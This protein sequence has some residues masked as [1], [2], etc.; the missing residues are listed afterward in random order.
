MVVGIASN[1]GAV[2]AGLLGRHRLGRD[3][4]R[5]LARRASLGEA[6]AALRD[7]PYG[8]D[9][10][11]APTL[12]A[13]Q[14]A[15]AGTPLWHMRVLAGWLPPRGGELVRTLAGWW[16]VLNVEN[17]LA[18]LG[19]AASLPPYD[20][21]RLDTAWR[22]L[23]GAGSAA[24]VRAR[25][26]DSA[27]L[28]P[29]ADDVPTIVTALRLSWSRRVAAE[30]DDAARLAR[31]WAAL[32]IA[33]DLL[34][35]SRT[36]AAAGVRPIRGLGLEHV[37]VG[38]LGH[39]RTTLPRDAAWVLDDV[40]VPADLW[41]AEVRWWRELDVAGGRMLG[42][43]VSGAQAVVGTFAVLLA[44]AHRVQGA[45]ELAARGGLDEEVAGATL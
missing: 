11:D 1:A 9:L 17:L 40:S 35:G 24:A 44:D 41:N 12:A 34:A 19:G 38:D 23:R 5:D 30:A 13:V 14:W 7:G 4:A 45:L 3:G 16:E 2:R 27:W 33:R 36:R 25:L 8:R 29:G 6:V 21:G 37:E 28:D 42:H 15:V 43:P 22:R 32:V 10:G 18:G 39:L 26:A 31:G 20:L